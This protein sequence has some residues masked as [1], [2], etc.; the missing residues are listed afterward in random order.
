L[1][2]LLWL[3]LVAKMLATAAI[4]VAASKVAERADAFLAGLMVTLPV[5]AGPALAFLAIEHGA[6]FVTKSTLTSLA[7]NATTGMFVVVYAFLAQ[8]LP[9][10]ISLGSA[11]LFWGLTV[12]ELLTWAWTL[13]LALAL[14]FA[15][16]TLGILLTR[17]LVAQQKPR[18][19]P[20]R[21]WWDVPFRALL[22]MLLVGAVLLTGQVFGP[23]V[24]GVATMTPI[25]LISIAIILQPRMGGHA[26]AEV[27]I[28]ALPGMYGVSLGLAL[29]NLAA[30]PLGIAWAL[31]LGLAVCL[32]W[33]ASL[34]LARTARNRDQ[35]RAPR[36]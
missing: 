28:K 20:V 7:A 9:L 2:I 23:T 36:V 4:V 25:V 19:A 8:R 17:P 30:I 21:K 35:V 31:S 32:V 16:F 1:D 18:P 5:S 29:V 12:S 11:L 34:I 15:S 14:N 27:L 3:S 24:A 33:N 22:V 6:A 10:S 13:E 26:A